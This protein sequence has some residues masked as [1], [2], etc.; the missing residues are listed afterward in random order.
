MDIKINKK[1]YFVFDLDD[2]L[3]HELDYLKSGY[4][5][6]AEYL[7]PK[8]HDDIYDKMIE[9]FNHK[10]NVFKWILETFPKITTLDVLLGIYREH[11]PSINMRI[12]ADNFLNRANT[13]NIPLGII[14][15]GRSITQRNKMTA[16]GIFNL[17]TDIIISEEFGTEKPNI[18]NFKYFTNK[19]QEYNFCFWGDNTNKDFQSPLS[20]GWRCFCIKDKG[21][22]IHEQIPNIEGIIYLNSFDEIN[23]VK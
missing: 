16:L 14:T 11:K 10:E 21:E 5:K 8:I 7:H 22:N 2:T 1:N 18:N 9:K 3:Y 20:L 15:D 19:Y 6:I 12:D 13:L 23:L 17:F 4:H